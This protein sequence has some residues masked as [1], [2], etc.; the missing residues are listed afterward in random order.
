[1]M[2]QKSSKKTTKPCPKRKP[3]WSQNRS[4]IEFFHKK[5][6]IDKLKIL[7]G[8]SSTKKQPK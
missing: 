3:K 1:M 5:E 4:N 7:T 8:I 6:A 2:F